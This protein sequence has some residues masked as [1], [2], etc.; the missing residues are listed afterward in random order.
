MKHMILLRFVYSFLLMASIYG[1]S[2]Q[3][4][5]VNNSPCATLNATVQIKP[6]ANLSLMLG[7]DA[8]QAAIDSITRHVA[9]QGN[10]SIPSLANF[11][12]DAAIKTAEAN[13]KKLTAHDKTAIETYL[14]EEVVPTIK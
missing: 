3:S 1:C 13:G 14:R 9:L 4:Q 10:T 2:Q 12:T 7:N 11:G 6:S 8:I 5:Q